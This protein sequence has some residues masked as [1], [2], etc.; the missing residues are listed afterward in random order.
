[1]IRRVTFAALFWLLCLP[2]LAHAQTPSFLP[3]DLYAL[4]NAGVVERYAISAVGATQITPSDAF[5]LDF[6]VDVLGERLAYRTQEGLFVVIL[7]SDGSVSG[8]VQI[9]GPSAGVPAYRAQGD[10]VTWSPTGDALAYTTLTGARVYMDAGDGA[11]FQDLADGGAYVSLSWSPGGTYLAA[12]TDQQVWWLYRRDGTTL[13]LT[14]VI[15]SSI[16]TT[17]VSNAELVFAPAEGG[18]LLMNLDAANAQSVILE[19]NVFYRLP[20]LTA[21][22]RLVFF[23]R[24]QNDA[25]IAEGFGI[26]QRLARG[27][28]Q[29]ETVGQQPIALNGLRWAPGAQWMIAFQGGVLGLYDPATGAGVPFSINNAVAYAWGPLTLEAPPLLILP[30]ATPVPP[31]GE[32]ELITIPTQEIGLPEGETEVEVPVQEAPTPLPAA[33]FVLDAA[34][35]F[36]NPDPG[37]TIQVWRLPENGQ[38]AFRFTGSAT[39]VSEFAPSPNGQAVT[40]IAG[41]QLW[42]QRFEVRQPSLLAFLNGFAPSMPAFSPDGTRIAYVDETAQNGGIWLSTLGAEPTRILANIS[43]RGEENRTYRRPQWSPDGTRLLLDAYLN[44]GVVSA[45]LDVASGTLTEGAFTS[46]DDPR[47]ITASWLSVSE[48]FAFVDANASTDLETGFYRFDAADLT[49]VEGGFAPLPASALVRSVVPIDSQRFRAL[50]ADANY[51]EA[52]IRV[53]DVTGTGLADVLVIP[54]LV[55]PRLSPTARLVSGYASVST[56][57]GIQQGALVMID[58]NSGSQSQLSQPASVWGFRWTR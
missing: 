12:E 49:E 45:V 43:D 36:L 40:Y 39:D 9:E 30:T 16:G 32:P 46:V 13:S 8:P 23:A 22:D 7:A 1:M 28:R 20:G 58:L 17:W 34:G 33:G 24:P 6:G 14:S 35:W 53:V 57:D 19:T 11:V 26:L 50:L 41:G 27:A 4:T 25:G 15:P 38:P 2:W 48:I 21:D 18:L 29:V 44:S 10:S 52:L 47:P 3:A 31:E 56:I 5:V 55:A 51:P 54:P 37:G 42:L